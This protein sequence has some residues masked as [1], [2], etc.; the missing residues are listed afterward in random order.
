MASEKL[1]RVVFELNL[2]IE[3]IKQKFNFLGQI[4]SSKKIFLLSITI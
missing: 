4:K 1:N 3:N 2:S